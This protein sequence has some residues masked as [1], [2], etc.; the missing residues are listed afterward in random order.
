MIGYTASKHGV[1]ALTRTLAVEFKSHGVSVKALCPAWV[2]T[3]ITASAGVTAKSKEDV[4]RSIQKS[5]GLMSP[6]EVAEGFY[7]LVSGCNNGA[8]MWAVKDTPFLIIPD[9]GTV[10]LMTMIFM[11]KIIG[12]IT[13]Y[14]LI[15]VVQQKLF[16]VSFAFILFLVACWLF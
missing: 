3:E 15:T 13:G 12:K 10:K 16:I 4:R 5:G 11:A 6:D 9:T 8:V 1:I 7:K 14:D 2:D